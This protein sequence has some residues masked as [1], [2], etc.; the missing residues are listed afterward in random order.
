MKPKTCIEG[1]GLAK[2]KRLDKSSLVRAKK[3][4]TLIAVREGTTVEKVRTNI[5]LAMLSGLLSKDPAVQEKWRRIPCAK[6]LPTP[7][8]VIAFYGEELTKL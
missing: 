1:K 3:I 5:Q 2:N 8:E 7:E 6:E 4:L